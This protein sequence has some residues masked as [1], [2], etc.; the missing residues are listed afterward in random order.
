MSGPRQNNAKHNDA[1]SHALGS[2]TSD[3]GS[4]R[5]EHAAVLGV[6]V[7]TPAFPAF[8][9]GI[10]TYTLSDKG[11]LIFSG[12][13]AA[14]DRLLGLDSAEYIGKR[15]GEAFPSLIDTGIIEK[16]RRVCETG[17]PL[18]A[19][20]VVYCDEH[21][22]NPV[23]VHA[24]RLSPDH[25][26]TLFFDGTGHR[27]EEERLNA[28]LELETLVSQISG[29]FLQTAD[30]SEA[31]DMSLG[32]VGESRHASRAYLFQF[33][34]NRVTMD[35]T[36]EWCAD[37]VDPQQ[38]NLQNVPCDRFPWWMQRLQNGE[39][40]IIPDVEEMPEQ[41]IAEKEILQAQGIVSL[42]VLPF[43]MRGEL[44]GFIGFDHT[45]RKSVWTDDDVTLLRMLAG[46]LGNALERQRAEDALRES[47]ERYS[48]LFQ[49]SKDAILLH[50]LTGDMIDVNWKALLL[51][52][53][54]RTEILKR[55]VCSLHPSEEI[56][57]CQRAFEEVARSGVIHFET[58]FQ[59]KSG[60][61]FPAEV[62]GSLITIGG[63]DLIYG[64]IRDISGQKRAEEERFRLEERLRQ[65]QK[66]E[67]IGEL[68]G[69][70]A[71]DFNNILTGI[72]GNAELLQM[73][74]D[75]DPED[76]EL[77]NQIV[78]GARRAA[79][80]THQLLTF[81]RRGNFQNI[82]VDMH[83][84]I[85]E[86]HDLLNR[87]ID[88]GIDMRVELDAEC[89][90]VIGD[91]SWLQTALL[92]LGL[93]ARD[94]MPRGGRLTIAT[95]NVSFGTTASAE[96]TGILNDLLQIRVSDTGEGIP[97]SIQDR[98]FEPFF[99]TKSHGHGTG[100]GLAS[101]YGCVKH[102][103]G[104][105]DIQSSPGKGT[106]FIVLLPVT[107]AVPEPSEKEDVEATDTA[108]SADGQFMVI[109]DE[110]I[111]CQFAAAA[112]KRLGYRASTFQDGQSALSY[113]EKNWRSVELIILDMLMP[114]MNGEEVF[115]ELRR[116]NPD[117]CVLI[118][119]GYS[120]NAAVER[121]MEDG[122][123]GFL[124]KPFQLDELAR[125]ISQALESPRERNPQ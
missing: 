85:R 34:D 47:E 9:V 100:M 125:M 92:N 73:T 46:V 93:N 106:S 67:A 25:V 115:R 1:A 79:E 32:D 107:S 119:S 41:A 97:A 122:A 94:A 81:S 3:G 11:E 83:R 118:A 58:K 66:M 102:H 30:L 5:D 28:R 89:S 62:S 33:R 70:I 49:Q 71:H 82:A 84:V 68:A 105:I 54:S 4:E 16:Y 22:S 7:G 50:T 35:N 76:S 111:V 26:A 21:L 124:H 53:Y 61:I 104:T 44:S 78:K 52:G 75:R 114:A 10:H 37:G 38:G 116:I 101:V 112:V 60:E 42:I 99:T 121:L 98:V 12:A 51:F 113:Y 88:P 2:R 55:S 110:D 36:H 27:P 20:D 6:D 18:Y 108:R 17:E 40:I 31:I 65:S 48:N 14:A 19:D 13:N 96:G 77:V 90:H 91:P 8:P 15:A 109:D 39:V 95:R 56:H 103:A 74:V 86:V 69:G 29:R 117:A 64:M 87:S 123:V 80:L 43:Y 59:K 57:R 63:R 24:F 72:M 45:V 23:K 120:H